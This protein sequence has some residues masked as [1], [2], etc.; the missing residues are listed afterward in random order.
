M[1][2]SGCYNKKER[3]NRENEVKGM[4]GSLLRFLTRNQA[5]R[6]TGT[7]TP[8]DSDITRTIVVMAQ[9]ILICDAGFSSV[10]H[11]YTRYRDPEHFQI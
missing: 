10:H 2:H 5:E 11:L 4:A 9:N 3:L 1:K 6:L 8:L 7:D